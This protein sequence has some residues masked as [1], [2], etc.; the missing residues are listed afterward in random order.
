[1]MII[2][3]LTQV[4]VRIKW[5]NICKTLRILFHLV[6]VL[7][8][9]LINIYNNN[10]S[11][12]YMLIF[13][14]CLPSHFA[15]CPDCNQ[16]YLGSLFSWLHFGSTKGGPGRTWMYRGKER[17]DHLFFASFLLPCSCFS[18]NRCAPPWLSSCWTAPPVAQPWLGSFNTIYSSYPFNSRGGNAL[19][20]LGLWLPHHV[21][22][23]STVLPTSFLLVPSLASLHLNHLGRVLLSDGTL[24]YRKFYDLIFGFDSFVMSQV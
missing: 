17:C 22:Y 15:S 2:V 19:P 21:L 11:S 3:V 20:C 12:T 14:I 8:L 18:W 16:H 9:M 6:N 5:F 23:V 24:A 1:M 10:N 4:I 7:C 13:C